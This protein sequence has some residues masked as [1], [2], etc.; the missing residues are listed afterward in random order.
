MHRLAAEARERGVHVQVL[1]GCQC[2]CTTMFR[3]DEPHLLW[4]LDSL[5]Q[6][7]VVNRVMVH[8]EARADALL[9]LQRMLDITASP[10]AV[11]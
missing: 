4:A 1:S 8:P 5:A 10:V 7:K 9:S 6:G 2:L 11:D 3:I